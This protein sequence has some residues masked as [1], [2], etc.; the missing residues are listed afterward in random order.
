MSP[1]HLHT[2]EKNVLDE[3][4]RRRLFNW[5]KSEPGVNFSGL[6]EYMEEMGEDG[7]VKPLPNGS[8]TYHL[9]MLEEF[10]LVRSVYRGRERLLYPVGFKIPGD[11]TRSKEDNRVLGIL[12]GVPGVTQRGLAELAD[13]A[14]S[15]MSYRLRR[16]ADYIK[17]E[18]IGKENRLSVKE[19][20]AE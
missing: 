18:R 17:V 7:T 20:A 14:R 1:P 11:Y 4:R 2:T 5:I 16:L 19:E 15:T 13:V 12:R 8:L 6:R 9:D 10:G 3:H